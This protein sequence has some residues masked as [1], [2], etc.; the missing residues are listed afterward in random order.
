[1]ILGTIPTITKMIIITIFT[2]IKKG[3]DVDMG[4]DSDISDMSM[5]D[6]GNGNTSVL[7]NHA[8]KFTGLFS[9]ISNV[10]IET[11]NDDCTCCDMNAVSQLTTISAP[12]EPN[13]VSK[14][15]PKE[16]EDGGQREEQQHKQVHQ[17]AF[18]PGTRQ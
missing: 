16:A 17:H 5:S 13:Y 7:S 8:K 14:L 3:D 1:M 11:T 9:K 10:K 2:I 12:A 6:D 15:A 18:S 4:T